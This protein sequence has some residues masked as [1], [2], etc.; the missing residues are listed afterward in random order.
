MVVLGKTYMA[1]KTHCSRCND[2]TCETTGFCYNCSAPYLPPDCTR[3][4]FTGYYY[5]DNW[6]QPCNR[7]CKEARCD[8]TSGSCLLGCEQWY[9]PAGSCRFHISTQDHVQLLQPELLNVEAGVVMFTVVVPTVTPADVAGYYRLVV[10]YRSGLYRP[11]ASEPFEETHRLT[12]QAESY[13]EMLSIS[14]TEL[15]SAML[16][17]SLQRCQYGE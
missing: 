7:R 14:T 13:T 1:Y 2:A 12:V 10:G 16:R 15:V 11:Q 5:W 3:K 4:C 6:C 17:L 8:D 9:G